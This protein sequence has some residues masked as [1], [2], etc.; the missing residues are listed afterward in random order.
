M[1]ISPPAIGRNHTDDVHRH[2]LSAILTVV[3]RSGGVPRARLTEL[4][5]LNRSTVAT[6]V[7]EL[8][9]AR[10]VVEAEPDA[11]ESAGRPSRYVRPGTLPVAIAVNPEVDAIT[12][13]VVGLGGTVIQR[14]R[15][16]VEDGSDVA[17]VVEQIVSMIGELDLRENRVVGIGAAVPGLVRRSDGVVRLAPHLQWVDVPFARMLEDATGLPVRAANDA[18]LGA[19]AERAFG[20]GIGVGDLAYL[21]G[22]A[23]GIGGGI[24]IAG[25]PLAGAAGYAGE[26]GHTLVNSEGRACHCGARGC[27]ETE[28]SQA[29]LLAAA[30]A[31]DLRE[32]QAVL[33]AG[34]SRALDA[35]INRQRRHLAVALRNIVNVLNPSR[36]VLGGFLE[37]LIGTEDGSLAALVGDTALGAPFESVEILP[38]A[39]GADILMIGA[40]EL[41]FE[42]VMADPLGR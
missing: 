16:P 15:R 2:N 18:S 39:L 23:S 8:V 20:A 28:V 31:G 30:G 11:R 5:G 12:L 21:N 33:A 36:V 13:G 4:S 32:L 41:A 27:L 37:L 3:H 17:G 19:T 25:N 26:L 6:L 35:E 24:V 40:A 22:G 29:A 14:M 7:A 1:N 34:T 38:A 42:R 9:E 10:L